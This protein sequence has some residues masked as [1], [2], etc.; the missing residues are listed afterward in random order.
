MFI[1]NNRP[2]F[3][4]LWKE[5]L[6]K[7]QQVLNNYENDSLQNFVLVFISL[8]PTKFVKNSHIW[9]KIYLIFLKNVLK[10][11]WNSFNTKFQDQWK[12]WKSSYQINHILAPFW[13]LI[14]VILGQGSVEVLGVTKIVKEIKFEGMW[15]ELESKRSFQRQ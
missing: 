5:N 7:Y 8:I 12:S 11:T 9:A 10:K 13:Y 1:S 15:R 14:P 3:P 2:S 4:F 6:G